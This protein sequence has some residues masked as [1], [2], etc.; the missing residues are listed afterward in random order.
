M[1]T[2]AW[3]SGCWNKEGRRKPT[4]PTFAIP[5]FVPWESFK[6]HCGLRLSLQ[7]CSG[8]S[9]RCC[10]AN[11]V[12]LTLRILTGKRQVQHKAEWGLCVRTEQTFVGLWLL[13]GAAVFFTFAPRSDCICSCTVACARRGFL[14]CKKKVL[15][16]DTVPKSLTGCVQKVTC[17]QRDCS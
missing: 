11:P 13:I 2:V 15:S 3:S 8:F 4:L 6:Q 9:K 1:E 5:V 12:T 17:T 16:C 14:G 10:L 7:P